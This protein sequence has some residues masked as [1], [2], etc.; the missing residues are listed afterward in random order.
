VVSTDG[1]HIAGV[2]VLDD[3][4]KSARSLNHSPPLPAVILIS[5]VRW[6]FRFRLSLR[7][8]EELLFERG[9]VVSYET[10]RR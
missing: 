8:I 2:V 4:M 5:T 3:A 6:H 7:D 9:V 1:L 10:T